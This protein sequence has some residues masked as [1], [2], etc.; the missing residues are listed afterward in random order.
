MVTI[1]LPQSG[2][3]MTQAYMFP[4]RSFPNSD[5]MIGSSSM[6]VSYK[7]GTCFL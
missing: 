3:F 6:Q 2:M 5:I 7:G 4:I 1:S